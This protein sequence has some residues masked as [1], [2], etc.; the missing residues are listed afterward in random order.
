MG[1]RTNVRKVAINQI[2]LY[3][4]MVIVKRVKSV[5]DL[6]TRIINVF[7]INVVIKKYSQIL[8]NVKN[9]KIIILQNKI[10]PIPNVIIAA[11]LISKVIK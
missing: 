7:K 10:K 9:V 11:C 4:T 6:M 5:Q 8:D 2:R 1:F 3:W